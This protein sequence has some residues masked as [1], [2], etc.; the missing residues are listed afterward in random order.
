MLSSKGGGC[1]FDTRLWNPEIALTTL[2]SGH[3]VS[4]AGE[5][6]GSPLEQHLL[7]RGARNEQPTWMTP[8]PARLAAL[9]EAVRHGREPPP[10]R[11]VAGP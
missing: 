4:Q 2:M 10:A 3:V 11:I 8:R 6:R 5:A 1:R 7:R 9:R